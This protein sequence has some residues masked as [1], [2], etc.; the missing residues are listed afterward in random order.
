MSNQPKHMRVLVGSQ[1]PVK[2]NA[3]KLTLERLFKQSIIDCVGVQAPSLVADQP[4][5]ESQT[6]L[7][8]IN[9]VT[10]CQA[11][12]QADFYA[13]MEGGVDNF[14]YGPATF[15]YVVIADHQQQQ[16]GRSANLP[17]PKSVHQALL[18]GEEL[19]PLMDKLFGTANVKQKGGAIGL[20]TNDVESRTSVYIQALTLAMAPFLHPQRFN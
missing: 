5:S 16:V 3:F 2:I 20:L 4:M 15:A 7:G 1:N 17:I 8:A 6:L 9:R 14:E 18:E 11:H 19:G 13:A 10:Y 12:H